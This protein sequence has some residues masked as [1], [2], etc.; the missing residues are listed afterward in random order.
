MLQLSKWTLCGHT[1]SCH[2]APV[3]VNPVGAHIMLHL[4]KWILWGHPRMTQRIVMEKKVVFQK[5]HPGIN[6]HCQNSPPKRSIF[7]PFVMSEWFKDSK[8]QKMFIWLMFKLHLC[9]HQIIHWSLCLWQ[10]KWIWY[11]FQI[12]SVALAW[13]SVLHLGFTFK[14]YLSLASSLW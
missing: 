7:L 11:S 8:I 10:S 6:F 3:K 5:V 12:S 14:S 4:S 2:R 13:S 1:L 9:Q